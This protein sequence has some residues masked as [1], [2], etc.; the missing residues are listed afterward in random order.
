MSTFKTSEKT[1]K[2]SKLLGRLPYIIGVLLIFT[3]IIF[4]AYNR[5]FKDDPKQ[6]VNV[7]GI[8]QVLEDV[9]REKA[10]GGDGGSPEYI[11]QVKIKDNQQAKKAKEGDKS[12]VSTLFEGKGK[13]V[14]S[15]KED[16]AKGAPEVQTKHTYVA[17]HKRSSAKENSYLNAVATQMDGIIEGLSEYEFPETQYWEPTKIETSE[18]ESS[19]F[20]NQKNT[21]SAANNLNIEPGNVLYAQNLVAVDS[22]APG[23]PVVTT[24]VV[25]PMKGAKFF[26]SFERH[27]EGL[28]INFSRYYKDGKNYTVSAF[29]VDPETARTTVA[30]HV[31]THFIERWGG[32]IAASFVEGLGDAVS[33][34]GRTVT[35]TGSGAVYS[36]NDKFSTADQ[37]KIA[38]GEVGGRVADQLEQN[39]NKP[40]TVT[41]NPKDMV[42]IL[43]LEVPN[44]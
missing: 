44:A 3:A 4:F 36:Q 27:G 26:G 14:A 5:L 42:G 15:Q 35:D 39:F 20:K 31:D 37:I 6:N 43:I 16:V 13:K 40:P 18:S 34:S 23:T 9:P 24:V 17:K 22:D 10:I 32:L 8:G 33:E 30:S 29:A 11:E 21:A 41:L 2:R 28:V 7:A 25:G 19:S 12:F 1:A 38:A